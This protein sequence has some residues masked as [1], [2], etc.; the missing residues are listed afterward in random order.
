MALTKRLAH[1][2]IAGKPVSETNPIQSA[3]SFAR[4]IGIS[5]LRLAQGRDFRTSTIAVV[6]FAAPGLHFRWDRLEATLFAAASPATPAAIAP[7]IWAAFAPAEVAA[8]RAAPA[9]SYPEDRRRHLAFRL[10]Y[11]RRP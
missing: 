3:Y 6:F 10:E 1:F 5:P 7:A 2:L 4:L 9:P 8:E 11:P